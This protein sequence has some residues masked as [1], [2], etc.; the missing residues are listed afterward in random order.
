VSEVRHLFLDLEDTVITPVTEGWFNTHL[1]NV[2]KVKAFIAEYKPTHVHLFSFA[3][4]NV[5]QRDRFNQGTRLMLE[6]ALGI[7]LSLVPTVDDDI[8]PICCKVMGMGREAVDFS[9]MSNFWGKQIAFKL[10]MQDM[11]KHASKHDVDTEVVLLD[12]VVFNEH[13]FWPDARVRG[14]ILNID[15]L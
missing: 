10:C 7:T 3:I 6:R 12:D 5:A 1:I 11:F 14:R 4:W 9:E 2:E 13:F 8:I 15:Q